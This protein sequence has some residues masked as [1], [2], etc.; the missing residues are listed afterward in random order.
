M[1]EGQLQESAS[2]LDCVRRDVVRLGFEIP[3]EAHAGDG[4]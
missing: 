1:S 3:E 2:P 4:P